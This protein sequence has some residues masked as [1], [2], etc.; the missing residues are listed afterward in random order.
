MPPVPPLLPGAFGVLAASHVSTLPDV[1]VGHLLT[2]SVLALMVI[3][4]GL[5]ALG[6]LYARRRSGRPLL[7]GAPQRSGLTV[8]S[9]QSLGKDHHLAV[10]RWGEREIL[11]GI[12][13]STITFLTENSGLPEGSGP[14]PTT[15]PVALSDLAP[16]RVAATPSATSSARVDNGASAPS[17]AANSFLAVLAAMRNGARAEDAPGEPAAP[18]ALGAERAVA[19]LLERLRDATAR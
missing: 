8:V 9:R 2:Q 14:G 5:W 6:K 17:H 19:P 16:A 18:S 15:A 10:V 13:G 4:G 1:S 7:G 12:S 11:V 3:A